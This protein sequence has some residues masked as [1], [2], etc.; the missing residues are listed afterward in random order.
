MFIIR[1]I[2]RAPVLHFVFLGG[3]LFVSTKIYKAHFEQ[4]DLLQEEIIIRAEQILQI[5]KDLKAQTGFEPNELQVQAAIQN[6]IEDEMLYR[7]ALRN[8][9]DKSNPAIKKHLIQI[10]R[11]VENN[12]SLSDED[13]YRKALEL[14]LDQS[15]PVVRRALI[16]NMKMIVQKVP[17]SKDVRK[18]SIEEIQS[19][20]ERYPDKFKQSEQYSLKHIYFSRDKRGSKAQA[21][22]KKQLALLQ[23]SKTQSFEQKNPGDLFLRGEQFRAASPAMLQ[24]YFGANFA[25]QISRLEIK[26]WQGPVPSAYGWHLLWIDE[27][28]PERRAELLEVLNQVKGNILQEKEN[29][30]FNDYM[31]DLRLRY[32]VRIEM[33]LPRA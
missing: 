11:F 27:K 23:N 18:M 14:K 17:N 8:G 4:S 16:G 15:D 30:R 22:A 3:L 2:L 31:K 5:R 32:Q 9:L 10:A 28:I 21:D 19:Y 1:K 24:N 12:T 29:Q 13:L 20:Y 6:E 7:Q 26:K 33:E 25:K